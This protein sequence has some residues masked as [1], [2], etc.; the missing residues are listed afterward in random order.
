MDFYAEDFEA[1]PEVAYIAIVGP[2]DPEVADELLTRVRRIQEAS[3][4]KNILALDVRGLT[5]L[6]AEHY[7][8]L[9]AIRN[10][11]DDMDWTLYFCNIPSRFSDFFH[12][13]RVQREFNVFE[14]KSDLIDHLGDDNE[15]EEEEA[16]TEPVPIVLRTDSGV[17]LFEG[18]ASELQDS[19]LTVWTEDHNAKTIVSND[20]LKANLYFD[21]DRIQVV[22]KEISIKEVSEIDHEHWNYRLDIKLEEMDELDLEQIHEYFQTTTP[23]G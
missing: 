12:S 14:S 18:M 22:P 5:G 11:L 4:S 20:E 16:T 1:F 3:P 15:S 19:V 21:T 9:E 10:R 2:F 7:D 17:R 6:E 8:V 23:P 13:G